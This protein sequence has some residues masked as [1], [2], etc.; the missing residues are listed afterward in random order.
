[1]SARVT[2]LANG[3]KELVITNLDPQLPACSEETERLLDLLLAGL[4]AGEVEAYTI[5]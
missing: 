5:D 2:R 3:C 1:M 4:G